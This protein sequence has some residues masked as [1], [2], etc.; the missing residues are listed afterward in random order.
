MQNSLW[1]AGAESLSSTRLTG[2]ID[3]DVCIVGGGLTGVYTAYLLAKKGVNVALIEAN[4]SVAIA[5]TGHSTGK[6]TPQHDAVYSKLLKAF[7]EEETKL[8]YRANMDAIERAIEHATVDI[9]Q[10]ADSYIYAQTD[11]GAQTVKSEIEAYQRLGIPGLETNETELPFSVLTALKLE[12]TIQIH[13]TNFATHFAKLALSEGAKF[14]TNTRITRVEIDQ[15]NVY[16]ENGYKISYKNLVLA[17]HYPIESFK[18]LMMAKLSIDRSYLL[19]SKAPEM[20]KGQY[21]SVDSPARTIRTALVSN[22]PYFIYG[23]SSHKA[24]TQKDTQSYYETL[25][26]EMVSIFDLPKPEFAWSAQD[27]DTA[28]SVPYIG[29]ITSSE[30]NVFVATGYRKWGLSSSLV[31]GEIISTAIT[32]GRHPATDLFTPS[33]NQFG[34]TLLRMLKVIGFVTSSLAGGYLTRIEAPKCT[35]LGCKTRWNEADDTWDC[36]C[37]GSRYDKFGNV[38]EGPAVYPLDLNK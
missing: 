10:R 33:R 21:I 7:S 18:G 5:T 14:Y 12:S 35:H 38:I 9:Y 30:P 19:A 27:P 4:D 36:P 26:K 20:L 1:L 17:T 23:G 16:C 22:Q 25:E 6:L 31:A 28:D 29:R 11:I 2:S 13:P 24:G 32:D 37:H 3:C 8:Y 15:N 34:R